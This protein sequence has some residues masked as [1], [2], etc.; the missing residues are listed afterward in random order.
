LAI[1]L[2]L[3]GDTGSVGS[4]MPSSHLL[5]FHGPLAFGHSTSTSLSFITVTRSAHS[6]GVLMLLQ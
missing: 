1:A 2:S 6:S 4:K 3:S 5:S